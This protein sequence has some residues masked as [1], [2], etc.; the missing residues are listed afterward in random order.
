M[1]GLAATRVT[2]ASVAGLVARSTLR[3]TMAICL[4]IMRTRR[5]LAATWLLADAVICQSDLA[6]LPWSAFVALPAAIMSARNILTTFSKAFEIE[7]SGVDV[8]CQLQS[9]ITV[10]DLSIDCFLTPDLSWI[11]SLPALGRMHYVAARKLK[12]EIA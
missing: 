5:V 11:L 7:V 8:A 3:F 12:V 9:M 2:A 1:A 6:I 10:E 4:A